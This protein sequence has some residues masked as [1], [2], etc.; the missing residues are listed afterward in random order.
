MPGTLAILEGIG[1]W[2]ADPEIA[3]LVRR[4]APAAGLDARGP[5]RDCR[6]RAERAD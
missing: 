1:D 3:D 4:L 5:L 2:R 6:L